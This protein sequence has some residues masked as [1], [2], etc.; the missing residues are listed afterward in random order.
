M[1]TGSLERF[2]FVSGRLSDLDAGVLL[3]LGMYEVAE[4]HGR[5]W[6]NPHHGLSN[7]CDST[8]T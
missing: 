5:H 2:V 8:R 6:I 7:Q 4:S 1:T 3:A